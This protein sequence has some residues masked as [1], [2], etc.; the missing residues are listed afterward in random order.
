MKHSDRIMAKFMPFADLSLLLV[1]CFVLFLSA[2]Q[3]DTI[4]RETEQ[5]I[6]VLGKAMVEHMLIMLYVECDQD[7]GRIVNECYHLNDQMEISEKPVKT[8]EDIDQLIQKILQSNRKRE[9]VVVLVASRAYAWDG[10]IPRGFCD[11][12]KSEWDLEHVYRI[13]NVDL[14]E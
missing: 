7:S 11:T 14:P 3:F 10:G 8:R 4:T 5:K 6:D 1:G 12:L 13:T 2:A 9:D